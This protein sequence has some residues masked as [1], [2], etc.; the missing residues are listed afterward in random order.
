MANNNISKLMN[1][2]KS[3]D[4]NEFCK[5]VESEALMLHALMM[6]S[7]PSYILMKPATLSVIDKIRQFRMNSK[8]P[9]CFTLDAG[10]NVHILFPEKFSKQVMIFIESELSVLCINKKYI[11]DLMGIGPKKL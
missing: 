3:G 11:S 4:L 6:S 5:L 10:A 9:V 8:I 7:N 2:L 1:I